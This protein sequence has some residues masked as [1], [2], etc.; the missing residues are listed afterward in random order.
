METESLRPTRRALRFRVAAAAAILATFCFTFYWNTLRSA[1]ATQR[2]DVCYRMSA[3]LVR[4]LSL[5]TVPAKEVIQLLGEPDVYGGYQW[6][7]RL[8]NTSALFFP[9]DYW[10][11]I[12][13]DPDGPIEQVRVI[14]G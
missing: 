7:Y 6:R 13:A 1:R 11:F 9:D 2:Y 5:K 10:L 8:R 3:S 14:Q 12:L 4:Q